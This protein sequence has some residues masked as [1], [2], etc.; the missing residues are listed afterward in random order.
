MTISPS[1]NH[2]NDESQKPE[3]WLDSLF[4]LEGLGREHWKNVDPDE[5]VRQLREGGDEPH[6]SQES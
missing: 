2:G 5:F 6:R 3:R 4:E 1:P